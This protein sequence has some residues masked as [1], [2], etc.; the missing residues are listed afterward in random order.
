MSDPSTVPLERSF[1][2]PLLIGLI[3]LAIFFAFQ[4]FELA[5]AH[6]Q[7]VQLREGQ[8]AAVADGEKIHGQFDSLAG[9][10]ATLAQKGDPDA[11]TIVA[12]FGRRGITFRAPAPR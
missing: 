5:R 12:E 11:K 2:V 6:G 9:A 8:T 7:L 3:A 4:T 10:T 1:H